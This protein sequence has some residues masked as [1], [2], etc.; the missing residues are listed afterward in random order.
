M[1]PKF[2]PNEVKFGEWE[3]RW[4]NSVENCN[5]VAYGLYFSAYF[6]VSPLCWR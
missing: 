2:D 1:P 4:E 6:S 5:V 3:K